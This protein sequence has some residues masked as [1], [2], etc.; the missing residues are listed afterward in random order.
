N[1][2]CVCGPKRFTRAHYHD[3][4]LAV[5]DL[6]HKHQYPAVRVQTD[7]DPKTSFDRR[8]KTVN[9]TLS[10]DQRRRLDV[11]FEGNNKDALPDATL[12]AQL[13]FDKAASTDDVEVA[14]SAKALTDFLQDK[15]YFDA[16]V[17][18][19][20]RLRF[21]EMDRIIYRVETGPIRQ[22]VDVSFVRPDGSAP[23]AIAR[24]KLAS[25]T[26]TKKKAGLLGA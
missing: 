26:T 14:E 16:R 2:G 9:F 19:I 6:F 22:T 1:W 8:T 3:D 24:D 10:I 4:L 11:V 12:K 5:T 25:L 7:F 23:K 20:P 15:G 13:T 17:T 18:S 21:P